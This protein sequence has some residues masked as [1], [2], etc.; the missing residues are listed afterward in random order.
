MELLSSSLAR[1]TW[2][3]YAAAITLWDEFSRKNETKTE[4]LFHNCSLIA[5]CCW[6]CKEKDLAASTVTLYCSALEKIKEWGRELGKGGKVLEKGLLRGVKNAKGRERETRSKR[7]PVELVTVELLRKIRRGL[8]GDMFPPL[9]SQSVWASCLTAFWG[10]FRLGELLAVDKGGF[11]RFSTLLWRDVTVTAGEAELVIRSAKIP[12]SPGN[13]ARL[14][15]LSDKSL[16]PVTALH[17]LEKSQKNLRMWDPSL[18]VFRK[19]NGECLTKKELLDSVNSVLRTFG[20]KIGGKSF[21][22]GL[23]SELENFPVQFCES[24][25]KALGRWKGSSYQTYMRNDTPEFKWVFEQVAKTVLNN[26]VSQV[27]GEE[28]PAPSTTFWT[29]RT[30]RKSQIQACQTL[31]NRIGIR[32]KNTGSG[33][34]AS[35][36]FGSQK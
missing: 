27:S 4:M 17:R 34:G 28:D 21:R 12:G 13:L 10:A 5:F 36:R 20:E 35:K 16:C 8:N 3:K 23:P 15:A 31:P 32:N 19:D 6:C 1:N 22:S 14:F 2:G 30:P 11:D 24:H 18:P 9:T 33:G 25:L 29:P 7:E 26:V